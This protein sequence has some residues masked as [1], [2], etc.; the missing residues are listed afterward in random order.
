MSLV[1]ETSRLRLRRLIA[2]DLADLI[3]LDRDPE[4]MRYVGSP[5]GARSPAETE[6]RARGRILESQRGDHEPLGFWRIGARADD[7]FLGLGALLRMPAGPNAAG[8]GDPDVEVAYRLVRTA[9]GR[10][11]ATEAAGALVAHGLATFGLSRLV[12]VTYPEN[13]ASQRVLDKLGFERRG[14]TEYKGVRTTFHVLTREAWSARP[15][16]PG[17]DF[18]RAGP[19]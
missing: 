14:L 11:V 8:A 2:A 9:W 4:V 13:R 7:G 1:L 17:I 19:P 6:E 15:A 18:V 16:P 3:A 12:A 5:A 10:G